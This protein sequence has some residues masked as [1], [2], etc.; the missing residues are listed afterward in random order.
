M[1]PFPILA[2]AR[3]ANLGKPVPR[4]PALTSLLPL[5]CNLSNI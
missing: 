1:S 2:P 5:V 3:P 4:Q